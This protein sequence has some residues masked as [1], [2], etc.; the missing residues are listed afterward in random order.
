MSKQI[1]ADGDTWTARLGEKQTGTTA[2]PVLFFCTTTNQRPYRVVEVPADR[3]E[4]DA[5]LDGLT[6]EE[7]R[8][9]FADSRSMGVTREYPKYTA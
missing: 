9:L 3:F 6:E 7:L 1:K 4:G 2:R 5:D 8:G